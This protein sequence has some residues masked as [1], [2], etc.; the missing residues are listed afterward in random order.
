MSVEY[1]SLALDY[2]FDIVSEACIFRNG[3]VEKL[4]KIPE[5]C[6]IEEY[7]NRHL[8]KDKMR[9]FPP[10]LQPN[11]P[12]ITYASNAAPS[13]LIRKLTLSGFESTILIFRAVL[14]NFDVVY[15]AYITDYGA[16][17]AT[18]QYSAGIETSV[19]VIFTT[20]ETLARFHQTEGAGTAYNFV[21]LW[22]IRLKIENWPM[23]FEAYTYLSIPGP[24]EI[25][26]KSIGLEKIAF[27]GRRKIFMSERN[28]QKLIC[29]KMNGIESSDEQL[30]KFVLEQCGEEGKTVRDRRRE[31]LKKFAGSFKYSRYDVIEV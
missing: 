9:S 27:K 23:Y 3:Q 7:V 20:P 19:Y 2:P 12:I 13:Q 24:L 8:P 17:P 18:L 14:Q 1:L 11:P 10:P 15:S 26:G 31:F 29:E 22:D 28:V 25:D 16:L 5:D 6:I 4:E 30:E 21:R